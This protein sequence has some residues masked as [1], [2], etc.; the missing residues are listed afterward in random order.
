[1]TVEYQLGTTQSRL[2]TL[3]IDLKYIHVHIGLY[4]SIC[5]CVYACLLYNH[6]RQKKRHAAGKVT[7][8]VKV[9]LPSY[10]AARNGERNPGMCHRM[11]DIRYVTPD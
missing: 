1:M 11:N 4:D 6:Q 8:I 10:A 7:Q 9:N 2:Y 3:S 5:M